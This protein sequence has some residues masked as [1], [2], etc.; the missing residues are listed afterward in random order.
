MCC[1]P[2]PSGGG[3]QGAPPVC[4]CRRPT[5]HEGQQQR[6]H[7]SAQGAAQFGGRHPSAGRGAERRERGQA[8]R[9]AQGY[10]GRLAALRPA[11]L[12]ACWL[13]ARDWTG[14]RRAAPPRCFSSFIAAGAAGEVPE[15]APPLPGGRAK[16]AP[17]KAVPGAR[18]CP[19]SHAR[20][21]P[22]APPRPSARSSPP[23][24]RRASFPLRRRVRLLGCA[25]DEALPGARDAEPPFNSRGRSGRCLPGEC[26]IHGILSKFYSQD[27]GREMIPSGTKKLAF[28]LPETKTK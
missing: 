11:C 13:L 7:G 20:R 16:P 1:A 9:R 14:S 18:P 8:Q 4:P 5:H 26:G 23:S 22:A 25:P 24:P 6:A 27:N 17:G 3:D 2:Y 10:V 28:V 12:G 19:R 21:C 15:P